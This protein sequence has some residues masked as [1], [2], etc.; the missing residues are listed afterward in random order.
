MGTP[1]DYKKRF[2]EDL[3]FQINSITKAEQVAKEADEYY[4]FDS[5]VKRYEVAYKYKCAAEYLSRIPERKRD[6][7]EYYHYSGHHFRKIE[8]WREAGDAY[9]KAGEIAYELAI[10]L[11][12]MGVFEDAK[13]RCEWS[14]RSYGRA[15][16]CYQDVGDTDQARD[17]YIKE[18]DV[19]RLLALIYAIINITIPSQLVVQRLI[20]HVLKFIQLTF[21]KWTSNYGESITKWSF[22]VLGIIFIF[23]ELYEKLY[24]MGLL[25]IDCNQW[26]PP[27]TPIYFTIVTMA[28][29]GYGDIRPMNWVAQLT[30]VL[31]IIISFIFLGIGGAV[32]AH[33]VSK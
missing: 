14:I 19:R 31:N 1:R 18:Y 27:V 7:S 30:V 5:T 4:S 23:T 10:E 11:K 12:R 21:W 28:T 32:I 8:E 33:K 13:E 3:K 25:K 9:L 29:V 16:N 17:A 22:W 6:A 15:K 20:K 26:F 24:N 2:Y